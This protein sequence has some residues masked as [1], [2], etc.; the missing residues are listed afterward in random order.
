[1]GSIAVARPINKVTAASSK[2]PLELIKEA[3]AETDTVPCES[4]EKC[5]SAR[6]AAAAWW[7]RR[8]SWQR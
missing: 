4:P 3:S 2:D 7:Q 6:S 8:R 5:A 1:M